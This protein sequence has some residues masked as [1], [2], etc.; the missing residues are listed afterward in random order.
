LGFA[1]SEKHNKKILLQSLH[2]PIGKIADSRRRRAIVKKQGALILVFSFLFAAAT[3]YVPIKS[4]ASV[5]VGVSVAIPPPVIPVYVQPLCPGPGFIW[6]PGYWAWDPGFG[7]FWVP[8]VWVL[9]PFPGALWTPG[10]WGWSDGVYVW[11]EG[12]WGPVVGY[13][14]GINYGYGYTGFGYSGGYWRGDAFFYNRTVN[15]ISVTNVRNFY[16]QR[17]V[18][19]RP[20]GASFNGGPGGTTARPTTR[21]LEAARQRRADITGEQR[22]QMRVARSEP[23]QR[24]TVNRGRP[25]IAA[26]PKAGVFTGRG[27]IGSSRAGAPYKAEPGRK[28]ETGRITPRRGEP[29]RMA[30]G[31]RRA[32]ERIAPEQRRAPER[33]APGQRRPP[34]ERAIGPRPAPAR[35]P[36]TGQPQPQPQKEKRK[37]E[38]KD[39]KEGPR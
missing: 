20:A 21:Q 39:E 7:Y 14:G 5:F 4:P 28:A 25:A 27:V 36:E 33:V 13:Y 19:V 11:Y 8:G 17:S 9:A 32:P 6:V 2:E 38:P 12:Y 35:R 15:N 23:R 30:P 18:N 37:E 24:A 29:E 22:E 16:S 10:Y 34:E 31:Q 1:R 3:L 26:T